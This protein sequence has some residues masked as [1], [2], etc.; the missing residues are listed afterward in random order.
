MWGREPE[1]MAVASAR[2]SPGRWRLLW[3][4]ELD[5]QFD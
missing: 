2:L 3:R 1:E 4:L 5:W